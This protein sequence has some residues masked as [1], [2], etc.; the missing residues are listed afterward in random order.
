MRQQDTLIFDYP[1]GHLGYI[2]Y[3]YYNHHLP[4]LT[5]ERPGLFPSAAA[6]CHCGAVGEAECE[7]GRGL[8]WPLKISSC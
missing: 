7:A 6:P 1:M 3:L 2:G 8:S 5:P 4:V